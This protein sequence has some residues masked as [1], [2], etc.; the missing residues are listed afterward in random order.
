MLLLLCKASPSF[1]A[2]GLWLLLLLLLLLRLL[3]FLLHF[4]LLLLLL[5]RCWRQ[6]LNKLSCCKLL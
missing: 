4:L 1:D 3:H 2:P 5:S 6:H